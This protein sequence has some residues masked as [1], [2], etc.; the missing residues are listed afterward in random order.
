[1]SQGPGDVIQACTQLD[2]SVKVDLEVYEAEGPRSTA[3]SH[4]PQACYSP[5]VYRNK[6]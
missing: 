2:N 4:D 5:K 3:G 6:T 1:M